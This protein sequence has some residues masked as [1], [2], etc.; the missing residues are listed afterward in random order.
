HV[1][2]YQRKFMRKSLLLFTSIIMNNVAINAMEL[3]CSQPKRKVPSLK[4]IAGEYL[5]DHKDKNN[6]PCD[7]I[8]TLFEHLQCEDLENDLKK[9]FLTK[10]ALYGIHKGYNGTK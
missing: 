7:H 2:F 4:T 6:H 9:Q 5:L 10:Y 1:L 3:T 8:N